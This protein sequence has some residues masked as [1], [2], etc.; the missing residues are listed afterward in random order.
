MRPT[1]CPPFPCVL[2]LVFPEI[3][4]VQRVGER[5]LK[6]LEELRARRGRPRHPSNR[7]PRPGGSLAPRKDDVPA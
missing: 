5:G 6:R 3:V 2:T 4:E 1:T 7:P